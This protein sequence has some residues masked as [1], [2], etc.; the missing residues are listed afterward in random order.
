MASIKNATQPPPVVRAPQPGARPAPQ[1]LTAQAAAQAAAQQAALTA[2]ATAQA[3]QLA[4]AQATTQA[5]AQLIAAQQQQQAQAA[6]LAQA[7]EQAEESEADDGAEDHQEPIPV[8][9]TAEQKAER[10]KRQQMASILGLSVP[11][12]KCFT[13]LS[14]NINSEELRNKTIEANGVNTN[15]KKELQGLQALTEKTAEQQARILA[16]PEEIVQIK[17]ELT[18]LHD[19][20]YRIAEETPVAVAAA[21][22][23]V[24]TDLIIHATERTLNSPGKSRTVTVAHIHQAPEQMETYPVFCNVK[25]FAEY[26]PEIEEQLAIQRS[27]ATATKKDKAAELKAA[28]IKPVRARRK[29]DDDSTAGGKRGLCSNVNNAIQLCKKDIESHKGVRYSNRFREYVADVLN[30]II[31]RISVHLVVL[32][33]KKARTIKAEHVIDALSLM[34]AD[35]HGIQVINPET[36]NITILSFIN[37]KLDCFK[38][39][40]VVNKEAHL[41]ALPEDKKL[42]LEEKKAALAAQRKAKQLQAAMRSKEK[43][44]AKLSQLSVEVGAQALTPPA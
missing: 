9:E 11:P 13:Q 23:K 44:E 43:L 5:A 1:P 8:N 35:K 2:Q 14:N 29:A 41:A 30:D 27:E 17:A 28:G 22:H 24:A 4:A 25:T 19:Q 32:V 12:S 33:G 42:A 20:Q 38:S 34:L 18:N 6:I 40:K 31:K 37:L 15:L 10:Q 21:L 7:T 26:S 3:A 16:I 39:H 36:A